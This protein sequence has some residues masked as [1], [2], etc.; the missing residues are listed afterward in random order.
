MI[1]VHRV[2]PHAIATILEKAPL[3]SEKVGFAWRMAVGPAVGRATTVELREGVLYVR[4]KEAAWQR[5]IERSAGL[6]RARLGEL[7]G[8]G[9]VRRIAVA[10]K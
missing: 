5:E 1:P 2:L 10:K 6:I 9:V 4:A 3:T 7:L 8:D